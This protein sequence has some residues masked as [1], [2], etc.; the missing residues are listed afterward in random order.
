[1]K[2][3]KKVNHFAPPRV[4]VVFG[5]MW[6]AILPEIRS[7]ES[8]N[9]DLHLAPLEIL[10]S[11]YQ[12]EHEISDI[13]E[14]VGRTF[15]NTGGRN[16]TQIRPRPEVAQLNI[17]RNQIKSYSHLL[18]IGLSKKEGKLNDTSEGTSESWD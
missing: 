9:P 1:M 4:G 5:R 13:I 10:C 18:G 2:P 3:A 7:R 14:L 17:V 16:G 11:L 12:D 15:E 8:F 6:N